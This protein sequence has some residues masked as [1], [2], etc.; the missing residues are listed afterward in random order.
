MK[1]SDI[2][3]Y[4]VSELTRTIK[5]L[6]E[7]GLPPISVIGELSN[8]KLH[9]SG[10]LYFTLKDE[11]SQISG[12]MW[13]SRVSSLAFQPAEGMKV[14]VSGRVTLYEVRGVYQLDATSMRP[15]GAGELQMAFEALKQK[16][17]AEGLFDSSRKRPVPAIPSR[18]GVITSTT[19]AVLHDI[20]TVLRRR[21]PM[22]TVVVNPAKVQGEGASGEI[23]KALGELNAYAAVD[24]IILA[25]GGGSLEDLWAFNEEAVARAIAAS[26]IPVVSA[27]GH[28][29]DFT[30]ADFVADLR[31]PT[32]SA[33]AEMV[34][35]DRRAILELVRNSWYSIETSM[36]EALTVRRDTIRHLLQSYAFNRPVD[37]LRQSSQRID[38][39][40][41]SLARAGSHYLALTGADV[42]A[43]HDRI[44]ALDPALALKRG[45]VMVLRDGGIVGSSK[46]LAAGDDVDLRFH[47][48]TLRS[49]V[50]GPQRR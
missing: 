8:V 11:S 15:A 50:I 39:L 38:E 33:A 1:R 24:V 23:A 48:G 13:R 35:P 27:V 29:T 28:E 14:L 37:S 32:P 43:L 31:A 20:L 7:G 34:V 6:L 40:M 49:T 30:I 47:D 21:F 9:G 45:Y 3:P 44:V 46:A 17:S 36:Q 10:H 42:S 12:V 16:L 5:L 2:T 22:V 26:R 18:I 19:G 41:R 25:R 4:S